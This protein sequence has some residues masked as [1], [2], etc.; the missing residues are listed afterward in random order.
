MIIARR[1]AWLSIVWF[2]PFSAPA[3]DNNQLAAFSV[4]PADVRCVVITVTAAQ[5]LRKSFDVVPGLPTTLSFQGL[6]LGDVTLAEQA[7]RENCAAVT[8]RSAPNWSSNES[9]V[10][11]EAG[12]VSQVSIDLH[13]SHL[14]GQAVIQSQFIDDGGDPAGVS[15]PA[16]RVVHVVGGNGSLGWFTLLWP[17]FAVLNPFNQIFA[18]DDPANAVQML[19][20]DHPLF[21]RKRGARTIWQDA[22]LNVQPTVFVAGTNQAHSINPVTTTLAGGPE[23]M[24]AGA[25]LQA[26][27]GSAVPVVRLSAG[28][29]GP[30][31]DAPAALQ[32]ADTNAAVAAVG[33]AANLT[34]EQIQ[35]LSPA[36]ATLTGWGVNDT[37]PAN[38]V[39]F[40]RRLLF[41]ANAFR[42]GVVSTVVMTGLNDDPH[43]AWLGGNA[44][45]AAIADSLAG[46]V[47][48]FY[49]ELAQHPEPK[50]G[51]PDHELSLADNVVFVVTGDTPRNS[52]NRNG[53]PDGTPG[54]SNLIYVRSNG[55]LQPGWFGAITPSSKILFDPTTGA[56]SNAA[57][58]AES[59]T[60]AQLG[61]LFAIARGDTAAVSRVSEAPFRGVVNSVVR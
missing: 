20:G 4:A 59:T 11:I 47:D 13:R 32:V 31:P 7:F 23:I 46:I 51:S 15:C 52:F 25:A 35:D 5:T 6:P 57:T 43:G 34:P 38:L 26:P 55:Y 21:V 22:G 10:T 60:A 45:A 12:V 8:P 29:Y 44:P 42:T 3:Q 14:D 58:L 50:C 37:T 2:F 53:W 30:A 36:A 48:G 19:P 1:L 61:I 49:R 24:A 56:Q 54:V 9:A 39:E 27:L 40:A 28:I 16:Q 33:V 41:A 18:F 17:A